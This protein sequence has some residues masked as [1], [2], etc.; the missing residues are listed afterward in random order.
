[1]YSTFC[2]IFCL[3][4]VL[5]SALFLCRELDALSILPIFPPPPPP[6]CSCPLLFSLGEIWARYVCVCASVRVC[7]YVCVCVLFFCIGQHSASMSFSWHYSTG[8]VLFT[9]LVSFLHNPIWSLWNM[10][11]VKCVFY[12]SPDHCTVGI[13]TSVCFSLEV[14]LHPVCSRALNVCACLV[15]L[16]FL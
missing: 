1:M 14:M 9:S 4:A 11:L 2:C 13:L 15:A 10:S 8:K 12:I 5:R 7:N 16:F 3:C 6:C